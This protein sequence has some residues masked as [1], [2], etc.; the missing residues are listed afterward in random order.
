MYD[1]GGLYEL[2]LVCSQRTELTEVRNASHTQTALARA[3]AMAH[4]DTCMTNYAQEVGEQ[5]TFVTGYSRQLSGTCASL[6]S[7]FSLTATLTF[8]PLALSA[9]VHGILAHLFATHTYTIY[10]YLLRAQKCD[11]GHNSGQ[12]TSCWAVGEFTV[13]FNGASF[14]AE[15][16]KILYHPTHS[17]HCILE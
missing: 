8:I 2:F 9:G 11:F 1:I 5:M 17:L 7:G 14:N 3:T 16:L 4:V 10:I 12:S 6:Q 13:L 15:A